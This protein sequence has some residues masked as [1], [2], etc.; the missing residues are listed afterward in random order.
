[1]RHLRCSRLH[2][3]PNETQYFNDI[4]LPAFE[5]A[6]ALEDMAVRRFEVPLYSSSERKNVGKD[7]QSERESRGRMAD[8][9]VETNDALQLVIVETSKMWGATGEKKAKDHFKLARDMR[10]TWIYIM[11]ERIKDGRRPEPLPIFGLQVF[12]DDM[13][14]LAM[15]F[16]GGGLSSLPAS[17]EIECDNR[18]AESGNGPSTTEQLPELTNMIQTPAPAPSVMLR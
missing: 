11:R 10:D 8:A 7:L 12:K 18:A 14:F 16:R 15:D 6:F 13:I 17:S 3:L 9:V 2:A 4:I 1:A 5:G